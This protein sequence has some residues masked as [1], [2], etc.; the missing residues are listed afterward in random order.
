MTCRM[1]FKHA[2]KHAAGMT[3]VATSPLISRV[4][5]A[6]C[7]LMYHRVADTGIFDLSLDD[8][9]ISP[10][11]LEKQFQWLARNAECVPLNDVLEKC[12]SATKSKAVVALTFDDGFTNFRHN[13]LPLLERYRIPAT[14]FVVTRYVGSEEPYPFDQWAQKNHLR[15]P[16]LAWRAIT[17]AEVEECLRSDL[18]SVG[19]H[20]HNHFNAINVRDEQLGE[21]AMISRNTLKGRLGDKAV[22]LFA[23]PYGSSRLG[24]VRAAYTE[25]VR[26]AGYTMAVTTDLGLATSSTPRFQVPRVEVHGYDSARILRAK[27]RGALWPHMLCDRF[28]QAQRHSN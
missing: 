28:R 3:A 7:V 18:V 24:H 23:Y 6:A 11:R 1:L 14:L 27:I 13:V 22:S 25:A 15:V 4:P 16:S 17:W 8:W 26:T 21:E 12:S 10:A 9:N 2:L 5:S 20:S 19:S